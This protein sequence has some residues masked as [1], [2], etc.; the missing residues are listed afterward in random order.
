[1][2][3]AAF[4]KTFPFFLFLLP[5]FFVLHGYV[6]NRDAIVRKDVLELYGEYLFLSG[7]LFLLGRLLFRRWTKA[8]LFS[9]GVLFLQ[10][11]FGPVHDGLK[12]ISNNFFLAKYSV[13]LPLI[14]LLFIA[15]VIYLKKFGGLYKRF[16]LYLNVILVVLCLLDLPL[17]LKSNTVPLQS[18]LPACTT[19]DKPDVYFIVADEYADSTSL[20]DGLHFNNGD[21]HSAL[22]DRGFRVVNSK[23]NY[24]FTPFAVASLFK[25]DYL[26]NLVGSNSN[27]QDLN[28]CQRAINHNPLLSFFKEAGYEVKNFSI[29]TVDDQPAQAR[30]KNLV[31]GKDLI[32]TQTFTQRLLRDIGFHLVTTLKLKSEVERSVFYTRRCNEK[33]LSLLQNE[34]RQQS[35]APR[36]IYTHLLMPHYPYYYNKAGN[37][38]PL[39]FFTA[40]YEFNGKAYVEYLQHGN[41]VFLQLIDDILKHSAKPPVIVFMGDHGFRE[42]NSTNETD[43]KFYF[44][45]FNSVYLPNKDYSKFYKGMSGVN[46]CRVLL[47]TAFGQHLPML[48]DSTSLIQ[49]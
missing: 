47:N 37:E 22:R 3:K 8:A 44:M 33:L 45:N 14:A 35:K 18:G 5:L 36:F 16:F 7:L 39:S 19:C 42:Y 28:A 25:M 15:F 12:S 11:F 40:N 34:I 9:F 29:F 30:Q 27:R 32:R 48:K 1:M 31:M 43:K 6:Q 24:N 23:S 13:L 38:R 2:N 49:E 4:I 10:L 26:Q 20:A 21:F 41:G 46:Q 17:L